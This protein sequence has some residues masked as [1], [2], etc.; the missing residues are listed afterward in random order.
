M[1]LKAT[2]WR[3]KAALQ[4][5]IGAELLLRVNVKRGTWNENVN[6]DDNLLN[7]TETNLFRQHEFIL[8]LKHVFARRCARAACRTKTRGAYQ[9]KLEN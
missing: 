5:L 7:S 6:A 4:R 2:E 8:E 9:L 1:R 3:L